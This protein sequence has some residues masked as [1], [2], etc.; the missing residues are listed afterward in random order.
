[1]KPT[2]EPTAIGTDPD[3]L[4]AFYREHLAAV[5]RFVARR[6]ADPERAADLTAD[7]FLAALD[8]A[9]SYRPA[10]GAPGAWLFGIARHVVADDARHRARELRAVSRLGGRRPLQPDALARARERIDAERESRRLYAALAHLPESQ[11]AILELVALD[12]LSLVDAAAALGVK[13]VTARVRLHR[14]RHTLHTHLAGAQ[15][16]VAAAL[17]PTVAAAVS[18]PEEVLP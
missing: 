18:V 3:A 8:A 13:P 9:G 6:V 2:P 16:A 17:P 12:G 7:I 4:E 14:A 1:M 15:P 11:R 5:Q 10:R